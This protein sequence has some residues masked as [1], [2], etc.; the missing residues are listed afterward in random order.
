MAQ[1]R[2][3]RSLQTHLTRS[4][5]AEAMLW[6][7]A[8]Q[9]VEMQLLQASFGGLPEPLVLLFMHDAKSPLAGAGSVAAGGVVVAAGGG[10]VAA[11]VGAG[12]STDACCAVASGGGVVA[13]AVAFVGVVAAGGSDP[14]ALAQTASK[15]KTEAPSFMKPFYLTFAELGWG[16]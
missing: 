7:C 15:A 16:L 12:G 11:T 1:S 14:H 6:I 8:E 9:L 10:V 3:L 13:A 4:G 5:H 2:R